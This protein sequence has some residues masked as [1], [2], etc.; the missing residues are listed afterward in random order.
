MMVF[1]R[2][3]RSF[4]SSKVKIYVFILTIRSPEDDPF[5]TNPTSSDTE[6]F[7]PF[8]LVRKPFHHSNNIILPLLFIGIMAGMAPLIQINSGEKIG[9]IITT[10]LGNILMLTI[11]EANISSS[12]SGESPIILRF[13][14]VVQVC[15]FYTLIGRLEKLTTKIKCSR[16]NYPA[17]AHGWK[18]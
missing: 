5:I 9:Y 6:F 8:L 10:Q 7:F 15:C 4:R 17:I 14:N 1:L 18:W 11:I 2:M 12:S 13:Y 16:N 3:G